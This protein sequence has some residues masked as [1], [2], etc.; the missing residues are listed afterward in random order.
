MMTSKQRDL[1]IALPAA[2]LAE[3]TATALWLHWFG[4]SLGC[5]LRMARC[6]P[7]IPTYTIYI[8]AFVAVGCAFFILR[9]R[10]ALGRI[11][12]GVLFFILAFLVS[13]SIGGALLF[14]FV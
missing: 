5:I 10:S 3:A 13:Q 1:T 11:G 14:Y 8:G 2:L 7:S 4:G 6:G 12:Y 9:R